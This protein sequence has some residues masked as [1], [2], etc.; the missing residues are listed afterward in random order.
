MAAR[1]LQVA[2][3]TI[4]TGVSDM[5]RDT[6]LAIDQGTTSTRAVVYDRNLRPLGQGQEEVPPS[7][8]KP[9]WVEH[10]PEALIRSVA[11]VIGRAMAEAAISGERIA[12]IGITDQRETT[13]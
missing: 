12:A 2:P 4:T 7:Y 1:P 11:P 3:S 8:P 9:G 13:I 10:D 6:L 5:A